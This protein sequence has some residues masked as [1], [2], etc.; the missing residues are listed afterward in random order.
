MLLQSPETL[1]EINL[2]FVD[3]HPSISWVTHERLILDTKCSLYLYN[4]S[5]VLKCLPPCWSEHFLKNRLWQGVL[6]STAK[7]WADF[8]LLRSHSACVPM[9]LVPHL[10]HIIC[11]EGPEQTTE[12]RI[13]ML[14]THTH[15]HTFCVWYLC[16]S[17][18]SILITVQTESAWTR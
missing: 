4:H 16:Y 17:A 2:S 12:R 7:P 9:C 6:E 10:F 5:T 18:Q 3:K 8:C 15:T 13:P 11:K 1:Q 14:K